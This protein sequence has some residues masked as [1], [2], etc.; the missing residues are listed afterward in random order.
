EKRAALRIALADE[1][2]EIG[3]VPTTGGG[4][5]PEPELERLSNILKNFNPQFGNIAWTDTH[6]VPGLITEEIPAKVGSGRGY[7]NAKR[8]ND[9]QNARVEHDKAL[10]RVMNAVLKDDTELFKQFSDNDSFRRWLSDTV[11]AATYE[12]EADRRRTG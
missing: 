1:D 7:Q 3:P 12:D 2:A 11:F 8:N 6:T 9:K 4:A 10:S 5:H